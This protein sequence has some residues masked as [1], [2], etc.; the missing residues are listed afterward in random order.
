LLFHDP[1]WT[2]EALFNL[3]DN[4]VKYT[5]EGGTLTITADQWEMYTKIDIK[6]TGIGIAPEHVTDIF[7]R[8]YRE[9]KVHNTPGIGVGLYLT[10][11]IIMKQNGYFKVH[12]IPGKGSIFSVFLPNRDL[13]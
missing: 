6:D 10:R 3:L 7:N 12:S 4:A 1:K 11:D 13:L 9:P 8:F 5:K 2:A